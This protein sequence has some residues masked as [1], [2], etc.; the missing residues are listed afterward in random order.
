[1]NRTDTAPAT[2]GPA[3]TVPGTARTVPMRRSVRGSVAALS[4]VTAVGGHALD[5]IR[6]ASVAVV[7][8][9]VTLVCADA[10]DAR[11]A[12]AVLR[13]HPS[14]HRRT[15]TAGGRAE[16]TWHGDVAGYSVTV[17]G[18]GHLP[19]ETPDLLLAA[20]RRLGDAW[21]GSPD[22]GACPDDVHAALV[23]TDTTG[24][25]A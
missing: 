19:E 7:C 15:V 22:L 4:S 8:D 25:A 12:A 6:L 9:S 17:T 16:H 5:A 10:A 2:S 20:V 24:G 3:R 14:T 18:Y 23:G 21:A 1:M 11:T 13:I